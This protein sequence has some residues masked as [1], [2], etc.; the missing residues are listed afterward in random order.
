MREPAY[1]R[2]GRDG[3]AHQ[4][5]AFGGRALR[6]R[7]AAAAGAVMAVILAGGLFLAVQLP[8][9]G[10]TGALDGRWSRTVAATTGSDEM[11]ALRALEPAFAPAASE[12][13]WMRADEA[14]VA[15]APR[16]E[17]RGVAIAKRGTLLGALTKGGAGLRDA[18]LAIAALKPLFDP[19]KL[20]PG[21]KVSLTFP[22]ATGADER[23]LLAVAIA[24]EVDRD[25]IAERGEDGAFAAREVRKDLVRQPVRAVGAIEDSL[26]V[27][28]ADAGI[29]PP[30]IMELI[31]IYSWDVD[32]QRDIHPGDGFEVLF[33]RF[34]DEHGRALKNGA[35]TVAALS[36][37]DTTLR[38]FRHETADG[39][40]DYYD[41][42]GRSVRKALLRTPVDGARLTSRYGKRRHPILGYTKVH[43]GVD[44]AAPRGTPIMAAGDGVIE[45]MG[46]NGAYGHYVRLRH[47]SRYKTAYGHLH[48]YAKG[49]RRG[50][51]VRQGQI[52]G[53]VGSTG[54]STGPH[55]HYEVLVAGRQT[56][57]MSLKLPS[58]K[59][60][61]GAELAR[62]DET[63]ARL[64]GELAAAP[65]SSRLASRQ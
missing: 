48:R 42:K 28:A 43:R 56:N 52:I 39:R 32:F 18:H 49:L 24:L 22:V 62:F 6:P 33:E 11:A 40:I 50:K 13:L 47:N 35:V 8:A 41:E 27:A 7:L 38:L 2:R 25:I 12:P 37:R 58:G 5:D 1:L 64:L 19:R 46:R 29:P 60:L 53:F 17:V 45:S 55:L 57:P 61:A 34:A 14:L 15:P 63:R 4:D 36:V 26:F 10:T 16:T 20:R 3:L 59:K 54:R 30:V 9:F 31:R 23:R 65:L 51:R 44:F 21:H